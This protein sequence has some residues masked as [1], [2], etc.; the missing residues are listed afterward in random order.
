MMNETGLPFMI[1]GREITAQRPEP[2]VHAIDAVSFNRGMDPRIAAEALTDGYYVVIGDF[3]SSGLAILAELKKQITNHFDPSFLGQRDLRSEFR[4]C[5]HRLLLSVSNHEL[6]VKK[7]PE[8]GWLKI[9]Y[10][11]LTEFSLPFPQIQGLNS[12]WQ[13]YEKGI[14]IPVLGRKIHP[15]FGT[16]F[17]TR[18]EHLK[19]FDRWLKAYPGEKESAIDVGIGCG[20]LSY[21]MLQHH[22]VKVYGTDSHPNAIIGLNHDLKKNRLEQKIELLYGDLFANV[23]LKTELIVFNPPWLPATHHT[24]GIDTAIYYDAGLFP[25]FFAGAVEHLKPDGM[26]VLLFS[27]LAR[28]TKVADHHPVEDELAEGGRFRKELFIQAPVSP[29]STKTKR[30]QNWRPFEMVELWVLKA[31]DA[32]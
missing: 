28:I 21:Q 25:R 18:F 17:P 31:V 29:A 10:P 7:A 3:Y 15:F 20:V 30:N 23:N 11:E 9:L 22:F 13:W 24:E 1:S 4:T 16:Y 32:K 26:V 6:T 8:I 27:N 2:I 19:L 12:A 14:F 5:S